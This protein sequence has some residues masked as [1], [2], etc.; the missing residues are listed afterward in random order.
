MPTSERV[1]YRCSAHNELFITLV[2]WLL[3]RWTH[4]SLGA[5]KLIEM[6]QRTGAPLHASYALPQLRAF[7]GNKDNEAIAKTIDKWATISSI[8]LYRWS[9]RPNIQMPISY[10]E[11]SWT[12]MLKFRTCSW[13]D[14]MV[15]LVE[16]CD[17]VVQYNDIM[18]VDEDE[19]TEGIDLLPP[20]VDFNAALPFL[21]E[22]IPRYNYDRSENIYWER[23][24]ELR[25]YPVNLF[26]GVGDGAAAN[27]GSKCSGFSTSDNLGSQRIAVT[28]GTSAAARVCL[29]L[30]LALYPGVVERK[31]TIPPGLFC[32][33]VHRDRILVGGALTDGGSVVQWARSLLNLHSNESFDACMAQVSKVY[34]L[35]RAVTDSSSAMR[36]EVTMIP[37]L[38]G[39]RST[40]FRGGAQGCISGLTRETTPNDVMIACLESVVLRICSIIELIREV[41]TPQCAEE[42]SPNTCIIV[43][44]GKALERN[45]LWR[46][47]LA[48]CSSIDVVTDHD[49]SE[50]T[51]RGVAMLVA[52]SLQQA[53]QCNYFATFNNVDEA[54]HIAGIEKT[55]SAASEYWKNAKLSQESLIEAIAPTWDE[56]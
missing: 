43:A 24:P 21:R 10:S 15:D 14:H 50:G 37:F 45:T 4:S 51:S 8:C 30:P 32:Y 46:Q 35:E 16:T 38:G 26:I 2:T 31:I 1:S 7:Y 56:K 27:I 54:L 3:K 39:E 44:S 12:G 52:S 20:L 22:G 13:D 36:G 28:I 23:W 5:E 18:L 34:E 55:N 6:Y 42:Q 33:R 41:C 19:Y 29:N 40:G 25:A 48:D 53:E 49:S 11:A 47:M 17:G 9:G